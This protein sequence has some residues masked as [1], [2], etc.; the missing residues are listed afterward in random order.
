VLPCEDDAP[1]LAKVVGTPSG[2]KVALGFR[3]PALP[4]A[5]RVESIAREVLWRGRLG[6]R[7]APHHVFYAREGHVLVRRI[8]EWMWATAG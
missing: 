3:V 1:W 5:A 8:H 2:A 7:R 6:D 4:S